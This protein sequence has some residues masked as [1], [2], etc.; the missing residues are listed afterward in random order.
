MRRDARPLWVKRIAVARESWYARHFL[1]PQFA[2]L[3]PGA[4]I[5]GARFV[6]LWGGGIVAGHHLHIRAMPD[7]HVRLAT[8]KRPGAAEGRIEIGDGVLLMPGSHVVA[9][10]RVVLGDGTMLA[11]RVHVSDCDWHGLYD[12]TSQ[13]DRAAPVILGANVWIGLGAI[14]GKGVTI[15]A[16]SVVGAGSVVVR[17]VPA[18]T[19]VAGNPARPVKTLDPALPIR[20]RLALFE[21]AEGYAAGMAALDRMAH[22]GNTTFGWL[23]ARLFP[24]RED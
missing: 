24:S 2:A 19:V 14:I 17:D 13:G 3:G 9:A 15:G 21:D 18:N 23:R 20:S 12:R 6:D 10:E 8:W 22:G 5:V 11:S 1:R 4:D 16:N 7:G